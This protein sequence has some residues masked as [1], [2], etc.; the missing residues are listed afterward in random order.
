MI[1]GSDGEKMSK[2]RGN[3]VNPD[4][5]VQQVGADAFRLYEMSM[6]PL[7][8]VKPW[9]TS[10]VQGVVRFRNRVHSIVTEYAS[11]RNDNRLNNQDSND[12]AFEDEIVKH[13][14]RVIKKI[15][16]DVKSLNYN[17]AISAMMIY[18]N[19]LSHAL[20]Q[21]GAALPIQ[22][23]ENMILLISPFAPHLAEEC[24]EI[25]GNKPSM[26]QHPWPTYDEA[27][28]V[29]AEINIA[30]Q[31]NG[32]F[33]GELSLPPGSVQDDVMNAAEK[34]F[35]KYLDGSTVKKIIFVPDKIINIL[36][37]K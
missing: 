26:S 18:S 30:V 23:F 22:L 35:K 13:M 20:K 34:S 6:G 17:T 27:M 29:R 9:Q 33:R 15:T 2:S 28:C 16:E 19:D 24:W 21:H 11:L 36:I 25:L 31:I 8:A 1:L 37:S 3:V 4:D 12:N 14:H 7:E 5:V 32:K 10:Q